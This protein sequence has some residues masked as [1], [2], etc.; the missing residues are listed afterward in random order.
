MTER[1]QA[2]A[3]ALGL[4]VHSGWAALV[5]L[6]GPVEAPAV[7]ERRRI[8][9]ADPGIDGS[10]QPYH[11]AEEMTVAKA[12]AYLGRCSAA[13]ER[14][15]R[16]ALGD[17]VERLGANGQP[18]VACGLLLASGRPLPAL[19]AVLKSHALIHTADGEHFRTALVHAAEACGLSVSTV[20]EKDVLV[21]AA[22][23]IGIQSPRLERLVAEMG[24]PLGPPW[25][26]DEKLATL[27]AW[28][29]LAEGP[30][31]AR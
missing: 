19:D 13:A 8:E 16:A 25:R 1:R 30:P 7:L 15:A 5:G 23:T 26:Q 10:V 22:K 20:K 21:R 12:E 4:R 29:A 24:K 18:V 27:V 28:V 3:A 9:I 31:P 6:S 14:L 17:V 11:A 2:S